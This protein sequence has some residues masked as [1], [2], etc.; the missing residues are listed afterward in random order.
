M[1]VL[2]QKWHGSKNELFYEM[3]NFNGNFLNIYLNNN[4]YT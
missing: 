2:I 4:Y 1:T 3:E